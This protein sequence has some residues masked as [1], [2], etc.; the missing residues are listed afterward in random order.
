MNIGFIGLGIM[1]KPMSKNLLKNGRSV[2]LYEYKNRDLIDLKNLGAKSTND[3]KILAK[4][5]DIIITMLPDGPDVHKTI[6][7]GGILEHLKEGSIIVD[8]SSISP[9]V[10]KELY[11]KCKEKGIGF[12]D[13]P[14][15]GGE[16]K[17]ING[18]LTIMAGG[19]KK[20]YEKVLPILLNMGEN[21][22]LCGPS[23]AG[24][25][26]KLANN[27]MVGINLAAVAEAYNFIK[28]ADLEP[29]VIFDALKGGMADSKIL[30]VKG[31]AMI[32]QNFE[33]GFKIDLHI[34]DLKNA[35]DAAQS[36]TDF[37]ELAK[38]QLETAQAKGLGQ[39]DH[40]AIVL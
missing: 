11:E 40:S 5:S 10:S 4:E 38:K 31:Q 33:P 16:I 32:E 21:A 35:I 18:T 15:S 37:T 9:A 13:A 19:D 26:A 17:A 14:V 34:K 24:G 39:K 25:T 28:A 23:G 36:N 20:D 7:D 3:L 6:I 2:L 22:T 12:V 27:M 8:M 30:E 29:K 1:G